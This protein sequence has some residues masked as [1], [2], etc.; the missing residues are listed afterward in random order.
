ML[1]SETCSTCSTPFLAVGEANPRPARP[2]RPLVSVRNTRDVSL[3]VVKP[4]EDGPNAFT[5]ELFREAEPEPRGADE[6]MRLGSLCAAAVSAATVAD[7]AP[8]ANVTGRRRQQQGAAPVKFVR[9]ERP[10]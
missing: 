4:C 2:R 6:A 1:S 3:A 7:A 10:C 8:S 9:G 5:Q